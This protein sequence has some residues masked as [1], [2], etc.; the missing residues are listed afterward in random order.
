MNSRSKQ[1][2][3]DEQIERVAAKL[4][5]RE[6]EKNASLNPSTEGILLGIGFYLGVTAA[7]MARA[8]DILIYSILLGLLAYTLHPLWLFLKKWASSYNQ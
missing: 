7:Q 8:E 1:E 5:S 6:L 4:T 3:I 2:T